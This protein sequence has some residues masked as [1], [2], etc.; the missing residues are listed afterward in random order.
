V[1]FQNVQNEY[2]HAELRDLVCELVS[3]HQLHDWTTS[4]NDVLD[5]R[6][7]IDLQAFLAG[8]LKP[9]GVKP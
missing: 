8:D 2:D 1:T 9:A 3:R 5:R 4:A 7:E 6:A